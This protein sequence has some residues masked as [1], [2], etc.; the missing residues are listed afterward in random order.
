LVF[1]YTWNKTLADNGNS[2]RDVYALQTAL[3][4]D[5]V[6]PPENR[7]KNDCPRTGTI[8]PCTKAALELFKKKYGISETGVVGEKTIEVL[9]EQYSGRTL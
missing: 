9:N 2:P 8:G 3:L 1:P 6:Y 5:G 4:V 7:N